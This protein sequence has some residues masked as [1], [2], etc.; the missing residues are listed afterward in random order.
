MKMK[1]PES[2]KKVAAV[3]FVM[4]C[5]MISAHG[6][7]ST[8][9]FTKGKATAKKIIQPRSRTDAHFYFL[10][11][12]K[13][14]IVAIKVLAKGLYLT[15]E[16]EC[17]VY[18]RLFDDKGGEVF[19]GDSMNGIDD[20]EGTVEKTGNHKIKVAFDCLEGFTTSELRKKKP[21]LKYTLHVQMK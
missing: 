10:K 9:V 13:G 11:L 2:A 15:K 3:C 16:N 14:Q 7:N 19:I 20:W 17:S 8:L 5:L 4:C 6:Q 18:F 12:R 1:I 21:S